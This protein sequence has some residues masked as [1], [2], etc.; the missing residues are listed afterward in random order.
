MTFKHLPVQ[1]FCDFMERFKHQLGHTGRM[2]EVCQL[3]SGWTLHLPPPYGIIT[4]F[5]P[6]PHLTGFCEKPFIFQ[7]LQGWSEMSLESSYE[8]VHPQNLFSGSH[9]GLGRHKMQ[10]PW[11]CL[12][13]TLLLTLKADLSV[14]N[15]MVIICRMLGSCRLGQMLNKGFSKSHWGPEGS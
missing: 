5:T 3:F 6:P 2:W 4:P 10:S 1:P 15:C 14:K 13:G 8:V 12:N 11:S 9:L 7:R